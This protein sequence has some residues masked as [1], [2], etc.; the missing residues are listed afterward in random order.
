MRERDRYSKHRGYRPQIIPLPSG[1]ELEGAAAQARFDQMLE[2]AIDT[3]EGEMRELIYGAAS[4]IAEVGEAFGIKRFSRVERD[5]YIARLA[6]AIAFG[7]N[8]PDL[9]QRRQMVEVILK[10]LREKAIELKKIRYFERRLVPI[11]YRAHNLQPP[12]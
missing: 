8:I 5:L 10:P 6:T 3:R 4:R 1:D 7:F 11:V 2:A 12:I 9:E